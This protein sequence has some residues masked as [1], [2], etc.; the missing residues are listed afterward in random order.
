MFAI[1]G[2][3]AALGLRRRRGFRGGLWTRSSQIKAVLGVL[4]LFCTRLELAHVV[5]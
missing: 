4:A 5:A 1:A 2:R 3:L